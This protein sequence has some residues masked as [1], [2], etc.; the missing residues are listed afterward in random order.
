MR[1][2]M[3]KA[4]FELASNDK[5][6]VLLT[7]DLGYGVFEEFAEKFKGQYFNVGVAEQNMVGV[8]TGL[9]LSGKKVFIYSIGNFPTLRCLEQIRNSV[10]YHDLPV[11]IICMGGGYSYGSLGFSHHATED[12]SIMNAIPNL[13]I[14][15][16]GSKSESYTAFKTAYRLNKP[17]YIRVDKSASP[18]V[19]AVIKNQNISL[20]FEGQSILVIGSG[21]L[22]EEAF[23]A[24]EELLSEFNIG[25]ASLHKIKPLN[26]KKILELLKRYNLVIT[27]EENNGLGGINSLISRV[28]AEHRL[29]IDLKVIAISDRYNYVV[30][31][32]KY[33]RKVNKLDK[34]SIKKEIRKWAN[35]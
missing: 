13:S 25:I 14:Y 1:G 10:A 32:Q 11:F 4:L 5:N 22:L 3:M 2:A 30:G 17:A 26:I 31:S 8:A 33:L 34:N 23:V 12:L 29:N 18:D 27:L 7:A 6:L 19:K 28:I 21:G 20:Y 16:P 35:K 9:A 15:V 24:R